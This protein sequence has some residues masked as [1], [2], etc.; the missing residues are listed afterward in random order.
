[1][2][3]VWYQYW[4]SD[5]R[6]SYSTRLRQLSTH[7]NLRKFAKQHFILRMKHR[8]RTAEGRFGKASTRAIQIAKTWVYREFA[9]LLSSILNRILGRWTA[10]ND[11]ERMPRSLASRTADRN[12]LRT[13]PFA[14]N[15]AACWTKRKQKMY[16]ARRLSHKFTTPFADSFLTS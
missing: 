5:T 4:I 1:M 13:F 12:N 10:P 14:F 2:L 6:L 3:Y 11:Y 8:C 15:Y 16:P 9:A 7:F